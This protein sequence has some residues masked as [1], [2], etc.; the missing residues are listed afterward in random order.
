MKNTQS[1]QKT[2]DQDPVVAALAEQ[3]RAQVEIATGAQT[4]L[5]EIAKIEAQTAIQTNK[6]IADTFE[7][8]AGGIVAMLAAD[9]QYRKARLEQEG[10][11]ADAAREHEV[12]MKAEAHRHELEIQRE[13]TTTAQAASGRAGS[14]KH[15]NKYNSD[16]FDDYDDLLEELED[17]DDRK[18]DL[19]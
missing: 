18:G 9:L 11:E 8:L 6:I 13:R 2:P 1:V 10:K 15:K 7:K 16:L 5:L 3:L 4:T 19:A 12:K 17:E 14:K